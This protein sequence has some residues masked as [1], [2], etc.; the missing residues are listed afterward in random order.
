MNALCAFRNNTMLAL[1]TIRAHK[2]RSLLTM[3]GVIIGTGTIIGVGAI[4]TGFDG[5][6]TNVFRSFG[7]NAIIVSRAPAFR[8]TDLT[9]EQR[10]RKHLTYDECGRGPA[11]LRRMRARFRHGFGRTTDPIVTKYKGNAVYQTQLS[12]VEEAFAQTG[13]IDMEQ[14]RFF[15][16]FEDRH[17]AQSQ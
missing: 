7:P 8:T 1:D 13:Q 6:V 9:P 2:L 12:G 5:A 16:E 17:R 11:E 10:A 3:L 14:G 4:L 15:T